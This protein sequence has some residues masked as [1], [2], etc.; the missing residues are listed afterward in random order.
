MTSLFA[1]DDAAGTS[2]AGVE[3]EIDEAA[4]LLRFARAVIGG[5]VTDEEIVDEL[6][7]RELEATP[8]V[9]AQVRAAIEGQARRALP[10]D[11]E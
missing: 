2:L 1:H 3:T 10:K 8:E 6:T 4:N 5:E 9:V 11:D 7:E